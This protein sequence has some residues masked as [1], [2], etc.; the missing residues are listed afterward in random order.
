MVRRD[1]F[2][3]LF[4]TEAKKRLGKLYLLDPDGIVNLEYIKYENKEE[5]IHAADELCVLDILEKKEINGM[6]YYGIKESLMGQKYKQMIKGAEA[7]VI[8]VTQVEGHYRNF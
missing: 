2:R 5:L 3:I 6:N 8:I 7:M 1:P 4:G